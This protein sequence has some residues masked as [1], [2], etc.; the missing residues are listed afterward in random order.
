MTITSGNI[1]KVS[2]LELAKRILRGVVPR[3]ATL[4]YFKILE[5]F[6][7]KSIIKGFNSLHGGLFRPLRIYRVYGKTKRVDK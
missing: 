6:Y 4:F 7:E 5:E 3:G 1:G 2:Q